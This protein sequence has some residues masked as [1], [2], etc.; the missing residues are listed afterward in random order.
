MDCGEG[1]TYYLKLYLLSWIE[2]IGLK[3][4]RT[5]QYGQTFTP[6]YF[7]GLA[8]SI[9]FDKMKETLGLDK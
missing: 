7:Y 2:Y 9:A 4:C 1:E 8:K 6:P 5:R 3:A